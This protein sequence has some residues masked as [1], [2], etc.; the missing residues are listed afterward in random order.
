MTSN[1]RF[2]AGYQ[3]PRP[4]TYFDY[5]DYGGM[6]GAVEMCSGVGACRKK[7][8]GTNNIKAPCSKKLY[9]PSQ[10]G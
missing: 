8:A 1:L 4:Q 6:G 2:G 3:T 7:L 5:S 10:E 9:I